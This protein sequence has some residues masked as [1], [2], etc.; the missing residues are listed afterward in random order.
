MVEIFFEDDNKRAAAYDE[1]K[2]IGESTFS[3]K[4]DIWVIDHTFVQNDYRGQ[5]IA[6]K[7]VNQ[8]V[9]TARERGKKIIPLCPF[10]KKEFDKKE[11][12][13]DLLAK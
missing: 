11:E 3:P 13:R 9:I 12:Y 8:I 6:V 4:D 1:G 2:L 7:L 5:D 10:A